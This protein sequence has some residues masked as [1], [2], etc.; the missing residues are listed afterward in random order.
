MLT[1]GLIT[2]HIPKLAKLIDGFRPGEITILAARPSMGKTDLMNNLAIQAGW[3]GFLPIIFSLEMSRRTLLDRF[4]TTAGQY[5]RLKLR[6]PKKY[7]SETQVK[8]SIMVLD[9]VLKANL[10]I[11]Q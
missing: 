2:P 8:M 10:H 11:A 1:P 6:N 4:V 9:K 7:F 3:D 5:S